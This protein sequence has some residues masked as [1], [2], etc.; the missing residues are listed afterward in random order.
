MM[1]C[2]ALYYHASMP[3]T[4]DDRRI[5]FN[6]QFIAPSVRQLINKNETAT[7]VRGKDDYGYYQPD[8]FAK[9]VM[10]P[11]ALRRHAELEKKRKETWANA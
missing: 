11:E 6:A 9:G 4:S 10:E 3:N 2:S 8:V 5:G 1:P 7:L